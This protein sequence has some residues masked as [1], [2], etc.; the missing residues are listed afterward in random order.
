M[1]DE[2]TPEAESSAE[3]EPRKRN[4]SFLRELPI[5]IGVALVLSLLIK[6]FLVQ[7]FFIPS[8][9]M[10]RTLHG[11]AGCTGDR[12]LVEKISYRVGDPKPGDIVVFRAPPAWEPETRVA[13]PTNPVRRAVNWVGAAF[14][15]PQPN[16]KD[17]V[18]RVIAVGGQTVRCCDAQGRVLVDGHPLDEPYVYQD[19]HRQF[20]PIT[21]P[22]GRLWVMG[23][24]RSDSADSR[25][26]L[27]DGHDGTVPAGNVIGRAFVI[28][29]PPSRWNS[30][31][32]TRS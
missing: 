17:L 12:I 23:D 5:L 24:H 29:W 28:I 18:K 2:P 13:K 6:T 14:G 15:V 26:H 32:S 1:P 8:E 10:E 31:L 11:C 25:F 3:K 27:D 4:R 19:D 20:G 21:V 9:S 30:L 7:A 16:E 22:P